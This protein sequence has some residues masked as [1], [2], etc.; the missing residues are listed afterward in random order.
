MQ[1]ECD[2]SRES[3]LV[4]RGLLI[5][6]IFLHHYYQYTSALIGFCYYPLASYILQSIGYLSA[7]VFFALSG[8][9]LSSTLSR[10]AVN[11]QYLI[12]HIIRLAIPFVFVIFIYDFL[13]LRSIKSFLYELITLSVYGNSLWFLKTIFVFYILTIGLSFIGVKR[14]LGA[15]ILSL[16]LF[17][18][19]LLLYLAPLD[20]YLFNSV[21]CFPLGF[22]CQRNKNAF[23]IYSNHIIA[24]S[25]AFTLFFTIG[26][27]NARLPLS[28]YTHTMLYNVTT[29]ISSGLCALI[30]LCALNGCDIKNCFLCYIG[31]NSL[32]LYI[33][34]MLLFSVCYQN[35]LIAYSLG[36]VL[37][38]TAITVI[39]DFL[40]VRYF[41]KYI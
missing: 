25:I 9:G 15:V 34:Q 40:N 41:L 14:N 32:V 1:K 13:Y 6:M 8:Y 36:L 18:V 24:F 4:I 21:L 39:Y 5:I 33:T 37:L 19:L 29:I 11:Q 30:L 2:I 10:N 16:S 35:N 7:G 27:F 31:R 20:C 28:E 3:S 12:R 23:Y 38:L 22:I 17:Y 26:Y